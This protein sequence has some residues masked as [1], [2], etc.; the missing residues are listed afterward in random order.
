MSIQNVQSVPR[1]GSFFYNLQRVLREN[2]REY[3][4]FIALFAIMAIFAITTKGTFIS[5][6]NLSNLLNQTGYIAVLAVGMTLVIVIRQI[7]LSVGFLAGFLG[8][9]AAIALSRWGL[10][11]YLVI[12]LVLALGAVAGLITAFPVAQLG[13]PSFVASLAGWLIYRGF[14]QQVTE[15]TGTIIIS[16]AAFNGIGNAFIPDIPGLGGV[17]E[18]V[19]KLTL[20][21]GILAVV[22]FIMS[23]V[24][25]RR[26]KVAYGFEVLPVDIFVLKLVFVAAVVG[27]ITWVL[28]NY[29][30][31]S[32]TVV[33]M[34]VVVAIYHFITTQTV[35]G[36][37]IYAVGGNP[38]AAELSGISVRRIIFM[39]F[40]SMGLLS[41]LSGILFASRLT[42]A[43]TTAGT[44]FELDAIAAAYVGGVS[45]A[46]GVGRVTGSIIGAL[47][48]TSLINGM[49]L[50]GVG[51]SYQYI[52]RG[53]VLAAAVIFDVSTR[54]A[55]R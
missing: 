41:A 50:M 7:D 2:L 39:V 33:I 18:G 15:G 27:G 1:S 28:A 5:S 25:S 29:Q 26:K 31:L 3:G 32:W 16:D 47:V 9:V 35:L 43:S 42:S 40:G 22:L 4:M 53:A 19:H 20:L 52:V 55:S 46:G 54:R 10:S 14:L 8:A 51:I 21:L 13:I 45:A 24:N 37:H 17:L 36:R 38:D 34:L 23:E 30:G 49:N 11:V 12:P 44:L 48:M 6:R